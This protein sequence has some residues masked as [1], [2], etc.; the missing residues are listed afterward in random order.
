MAVALNPALDYAV[1]QCDIG[2]GRERLLLAEALLKDAMLR[3]GADRLPGAGV[4]QGQR[5][6]RLQRWRIRS[7]RARCRSSSAIM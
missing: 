1:V 2:K 5:P 6:G 7:T 4:L 3:Y